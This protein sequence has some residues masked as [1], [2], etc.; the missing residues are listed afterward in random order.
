[1]RDVQPPIENDEQYHGYKLG[2]DQ[3]TRVVEQRE[4][5]VFDCL[6]NNP[7]RVEVARASL[8]SMYRKRQGILDAL[9]AYERQKPSV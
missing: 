6:R 4:Q 2:F 9:R 3:L 8:M 5:F 7:N 1:M